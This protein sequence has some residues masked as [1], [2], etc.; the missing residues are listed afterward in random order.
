MAREARE[1]ANIII[2]PNEFKIVH[3][4]HRSN[5]GTDGERIDIFMKA[6]NWAGEIENKEPSKC[7]ELAWF[8]INS[9]P[10]NIIPFIRKV[11]DN[12]GNKQYYGEYGFEDL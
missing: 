3:V 10:E 8:N 2:N 6:D 9:L 5:I 1:E 11:I 4:A 7:S 12:I